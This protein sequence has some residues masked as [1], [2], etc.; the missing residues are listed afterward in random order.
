MRMSRTPLSNINTPPTYPNS[1][2]KGTIPQR[3]TVPKM[4]K[5][6]KEEEYEEA[7]LHGDIL[8][9]LISRVSLLNLL[10]ASQVSTAWRHAVSR[11]IRNRKRTNPWLILHLQNTRN[12]H[13]TS[14]HAYDPYSHVWIQIPHVHTQQISPFRSSHS[15][16]LYTFSSSKFTFSSNPINATWHNID[17]PRVWRLDPIV[18]VVGSHVVIAGGTC[19]FE[20]DPLAVEVY[21]MK[22]HAWHTCESMPTNFKNSASMVWLSVAISDQ[23]MYVLEKN[24]CLFCSFDLETMTWANPVNLGQDPSVFFSA[25]GSSSNDNK[26]IQVGLVGSPTDIKSL[27][28][29]EVD[30]ENFDLKLMGEMPLEMLERLKNVNLPIHSI[31]ICSMGNFVYIYNPSDPRDIFFCDFNGYVCE[32]EWAP[33]SAVNDRYQMERLVFTCST[34]GIDDLR[35]VFRTN[36]QAFPVN[37]TEK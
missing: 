8:D 12:L 16:L 21:D 20:D 19:E 6:E 5:S 35:T 30:C 14:T 34:V 15:N 11:S 37:L 13:V 24:S 9:T 25:I 23:T 17:G 3:R 27:R 29:W 4:P 1:I 10:P 7:P 33:N 18:A 2:K 26:L 31:E 36:G 32:W 28:I 22:S